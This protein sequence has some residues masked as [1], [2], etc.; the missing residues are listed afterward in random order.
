MWEVG[1]GRL[2]SEEWTVIC[3][4]RDMSAFVIV[5]RVRI[6]DLRIDGRHGERCVT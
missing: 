5:R 6:R 2:T 1:D 3:C 4:E